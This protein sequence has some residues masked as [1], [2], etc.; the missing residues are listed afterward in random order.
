VRRELLRNALLDFTP[1]IPATACH[2]RNYVETYSR[3]IKGSLGDKSSFP[4]RRQTHIR[5]AVRDT[6]VQG[7]CN[8]K[9]QHGAHTG[10]PTS[11]TGEAL[12]VRKEE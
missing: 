4:E 2:Q 5:Y 8:T 3:S 1:S 6:G 10:S 7:G 12:L 11:H 9:T